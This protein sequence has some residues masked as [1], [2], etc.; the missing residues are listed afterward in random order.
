MSTTTRPEP[1]MAHTARMAL[2]RVVAQVATDTACVDPHAR[3][4]L[5]ALLSDR[6]RFCVLSGREGMPLSLASLHAAVVLRFLGGALRG[7]AEA[8]YTPGKT[9]DRCGFAF[10]RSGLPLVFSKH[11][12]QGHL[13]ELGPTA[14][15]LRQVKY[16]RR[17][18]LFIDLDPAPAP[19]CTAP[20]GFVFLVEKDFH[21]VVALSPQYEFTGCFGDVVLRDPCGICADD[22]IVVVSSCIQV[23]VFQRGAATYP[24]LRK[25][26]SGVFGRAGALCFIPGDFYSERSRAPCRRVAV[27]DETHHRISVF[28]TEGD[29]VHHICH[30]GLSRAL[31]CPCC[32]HVLTDDGER[33]FCS[34]RPNRAISIACSAAGE[35]VAVITGDAD[36][37]SPTRVVLLNALGF[38][39]VLL[40]GT[41]YT[42]VALR[43]GEIYAYSRAL[44]QIDKVC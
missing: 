8:A 33:V 22:A 38:V 28:T 20:D 27:A 39:H 10:A 34:N 13:F 25:F 16:L 18:E 14:T 11:Y 3:A 15:K 37:C 12:A 30:A 1:W 21:C 44:D 43:D 31:V 35:M 41:D 29:G 40:D 9:G 36:L 17:D 19:I 42:G 5:C 24:L 23:V 32:A 26:G 7:T 2:L 6:A 4:G